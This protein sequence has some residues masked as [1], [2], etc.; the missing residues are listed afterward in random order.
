MT[1]IGHLLHRTRLDLLPVLRAVSCGDPALV[2]SRPERPDAVAAGARGLAE[3][4]RRHAVKPA[5]AG[6]A[7][8]RPRRALSGRDD[9][10]ERELDLHYVRNAS[11]ALDE[12]PSGWS[13]DAL[14]RGGRLV[15]RAA[16]GRARSLTRNAAAR[17]PWRLKRPEL[18]S[19]FERVLIVGAGEGG[20]L[21]AG[22]MRRNPIWGFWPIAFVDDNPKKFRTRI[23]GLP[24]LGDIDAI[25]TIVQREQIDVVVIAIPSA[26]DIAMTRIIESA[27]RSSARVLAMPHIGAL[28][29]GEATA[30]TLHSVQPSDVL[31]R[32]PV[33]SNDQRCRDFVA[34]R[35]V[36]VTGA[37]GS[38][39]EELTRQVAQLGPAQLVALD[40]NETG[41]FDLQQEVAVASEVDFRPVVASVVNGWRIADIFARYRPELV[42]HAAA[43]KHVPLMEEHP[44]EAVMVNAVGTYEVARAAAAAGVERFVL[45]STDKAVRP[46]SVMG[47]TKRVAELAVKAVA[48]ETALSVCCVRFGNVL[49]SRGSVVPTFQRQ[50]DAGGPVTITDPRMQRFFMTIPE[51]A[52]L[53]I[54]A[55]A[56]GDRDAIYML[57]MG[58]EVSIL[59]LAQRMIRLRGL[60]VGKDIQIVFTGL[61]PGEK[62]RE[63][64]ALDGEV[65][66]PTAHPKIRLLTDNPSGLPRP[67]TLGSR[68]EMERLSQLARRGQPTGLRR[69]LFELVTAVDDC[70]AIAEAPEVS[71]DTNP[72]G[73]ATVRLRAATR[74]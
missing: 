33:A 16:S 50:I 73:A 46:S 34:G 26:V 59:E 71:P 42:F 67:S 53:I 56:F 70:I 61:R 5:L 68:Q 39:G 15:A 44:E 54:E 63:E 55:G 22:E 37:A 58:K 29:R 57:D 23:H 30:S 65:S 21:L 7:R 10:P 49:G 72:V 17:L 28:L 48:R 13:V 25:P 2:E 62:L 27:R 32:P 36:L 31:G 66:Q 69:A 35:R 64:L 4:G 18:G 43:Y 38:I 6:W 41:L 9:R 60:R 40:I 8:L 74:D 3:H 1:R 20:E 11:I 52:S 14:T 45:V 47:A 24:V 19:G 51:A 12:Y